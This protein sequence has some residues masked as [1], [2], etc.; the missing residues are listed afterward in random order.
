MQ[1]DTQFKPGVSGNPKG[2]PPSLRTEIRKL[3]RGKSAAIAQ[4]LVERALAGDAAAAEL[5][6]KFQSKGLT[7]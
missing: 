1:T 5:V 4:A 2:R 6:A 3:S 7:Q